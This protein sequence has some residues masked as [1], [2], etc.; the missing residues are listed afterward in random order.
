VRV[1]PDVALECPR[2]GSGDPVLLLPGFGTDVS[3]FARQAAALA[4]AYQVVGV[5]PRGVGGSDAPGSD[6]LTPSQAA[7]DA[8]AV[9]QAPAHVVGTS[10][11]AAVALELALAHPERVRSL[12]LLAPLVRV[13]ARLLAV[14]EAWCRLAAEAS[15]QA[16]AAALL[17]WFFAP[18]SL[19]DARARE[20]LT[21]GLA[22]SVARVPAPVLARAAAGLRDYRLPRAAAA[23]VGVP[24]L[25]VVG[26][27]DLLTPGGEE[28]A[29]AIPGA[30]CV[31]VPD[32]GHAVA[33][34]A[35]EAVDAALLEH[36]AAAA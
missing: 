11:G 10:L 9:A 27:A 13:D 7:A 29:A 15:A 34:E 6:A 23:R 21:R 20:R 5:N 1:A 12:A 33:I 3:I 26:G 31:V 22:A 32:A 25:V 14:T 30:R 17:P 8:A 36:L 4:Q 2:Q 19:A 16:L 28:I 24:V 35:H 18:A